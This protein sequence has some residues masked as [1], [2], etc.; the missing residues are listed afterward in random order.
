VAKTRAV[1]LLQGTLDLLIL[2]TLLLG[3]L[4]GHGITKHLQ[5]TSDDAFLIDHGS[6]YPALHRLERNVCIASRWERT[7]RGRE[8]RMYRLT[9]KGRRQLSA[10]ESKWNALVRAMTSVLKPV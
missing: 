4:H 8:M 9:A 5:R 6:L 1:G 7:E 3:P 2:R 10:E